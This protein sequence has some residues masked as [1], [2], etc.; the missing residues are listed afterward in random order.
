MKRKYHIRPNLGLTHGKQ[1]L[2]SSQS[3]VNSMRQPLEGSPCHSL[4]SY[5]ALLL[6]GN[7]GKIGRV[8]GT[9]KENKLQCKA[10]SCLIKQLL[11]SFVLRL[12]GEH[13]LNFAFT[14]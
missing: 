11:G 7:L 4:L 3:K 12:A 14:R 6:I 10:T 5:V 8:S 2:V 9:L 13:A 1:F